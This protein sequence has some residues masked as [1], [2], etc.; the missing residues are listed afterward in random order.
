M[1]PSSV[2]FDHDKLTTN[3]PAKVSVK[4]VQI[5][6]PKPLMAYDINSENLR[7]FVKLCEEAGD[8]NFTV[9]SLPGE[10][11]KIFPETPYDKFQISQHPE[12]KKMPFFVVPDIP[13]LLRSYRE[14]RFRQGRNTRICNKKWISS[15]PNILDD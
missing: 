2:E 15:S 10:Y 3:T 11:V 5:V 12:L 13:K 4:E 9:R 7:D 14:I 1:T 6:K 8:V